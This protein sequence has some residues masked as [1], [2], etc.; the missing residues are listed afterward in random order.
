MEDYKHTTKD[1]TV[2]NLLSKK[3]FTF[4]GSNG[5]SSKSSKS[6]KELPEFLFLQEK[7]MVTQK[8]YIYPDDS[9]AI[10]HSKLENELKIP[11]EY[12]LL[13]YKKSNII[14]GSNGV[15][16]D[17]TGISEEYAFPIIVKSY[18]TII[19]D[20]IY[21]GLYV[22]N[23]LEYLEEKFD[24]FWLRGLSSYRLSELWGKKIR[25]YWPLVNSNDFIALIQDGVV[26]KPKINTIPDDMKSVR[27]VNVKDIRDK[28]LVK[29][30]TYS[31]VHSNVYVKYSE[32]LDLYKIFD[33]FIPTKKYPYAIVKFNENRVFLKHLVN[34]EVPSQKIIPRNPGIR[35]GKSILLT[36][37]GDIYYKSGEK[38]GYNLIPLD[39]SKI[40]GEDKIS[41]YT[42][43]VLSDYS[44]SIDYI[45]SKFPFSVEKDYKILNKPSISFYYKRVSF[46]DRPIYGRGKI[47]FGAYVDIVKSGPLHTITVSNIKTSEDMRNVYNFLV[48]VFHLYALWKGDSKVA[49]STIES[50]D[51]KK[52]DPKLFGFKR[53]GKKIYS[54]ICQKNKQPIGFFK[55]SKILKEYMEKNNLNE[56]D[57]LEFINLTHPD[58]K[59]MY[60]CPNPDYPNIS[61]FQNIN[62]PEGFCVPC[63]SKKDK[64]ESSFYRKCVKEFVS[65][66]K[67]KKRIGD[68]NLFYIR[69]YNPSKK[70][71]PGRFSY[72]PSI[73]HDFLNKYDIKCSIRFNIIGLNKAC[74]ILVGGDDRPKDGYNI[75]TLEYN[76]DNGLIDI[77]NQYDIPSTI[78]RIK[79][80]K[81]IYYLKDSAKDETLVQKISKVK[82]SEMK[83]YEIISEFSF[84]DSIGKKIVKA[85][86]RKIE[87]D[88]KQNFKEKFGSSKKISQ[89][90]SKNGI[91]NQ[92]VI[93]NKL[94]FPI[95]PTL[96]VSDVE[97][98]TGDL[99]KNSKKIVDEYID[100]SDIELY[101]LDGTGKNLIGYKFKSSGLMIFF[102]PEL[103]KKS[104]IPSKRIYYTDKVQEYNSKVLEE[105]ELYNLYLYHI[106]HW[107]NHPKIGKKSDITLKALEKEYGSQSDSRFIGDYV[108]FKTGRDIGKMEFWK[109]EKNKILSGKYKTEKILFD[110]TKDKVDFGEISNDILESN[111][112]EIRKGKLK[113]RKTLYKKYTKLIAFEIDNNPLKRYQIMNEKLSEIID[114]NKF[115]KMKDVKIERLI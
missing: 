84:E 78:E 19:S 98:F 61:F 85:L 64:S 50:I 97:I 105:I 13:I 33:E 110:L 36:Q 70:L 60:I 3:T 80:M 99:F 102:E 66:G 26:E 109:K 92:I 12:Q 40:T 34:H 81:T 9:I 93:D 6:P 7:K 72:L 32:S 39:K 91:V 100:I 96:P 25:Y 45:L 31:I 76:S 113:M 30:D 73:L 1:V 53:N 115:S 48:R 17:E 111:I 75:V 35:I 71:N 23:L 27:E 90:I 56:K 82:S 107:L 94:R 47:Q 51:L 21:D 87:G 112:R 89:I 108:I 22:V 18:D 67:R 24:T 55:D 68:T 20:K 16:Y 10:V 52:I 49:V 103:Y 43:Q 8:E 54:R 101:L 2:T 69:K 38:S 28:D 79:T 29:S 114:K 86:L 65:E 106:S 63:C 41:K 57:F 104:Y 77:V 37:N 4:P 5:S 59:T 14:V 15:K 95:Y 74:Y 11:S 62:H 44:I 88:K 58:K 83:N 46:S 42:F